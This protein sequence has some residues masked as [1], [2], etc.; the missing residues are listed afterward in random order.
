MTLIYEKNLEVKKKLNIV[1]LLTDFGL[2]NSYVAQ[3][4]GVIYSIAPQ[5]KCVNITNCV[6][7]QKV[8]VG[9]F[10]LESSVDFF[11]KGTIHLGVVDPGVGTSNLISA[12][13]QD[14]FIQKMD[15]SGNFIWAKS[16]GGTGT[17]SGYGRAIAVDGSGNIYTTGSFR[18]VVD[19]DPGTGTSNLTSAGSN[20][21]FVHKMDSS[22]SFIWA[23]TMG[24]TNS[25]IGKSIAT[26]ASGNI[27]TTGWF[28]GTVDFDP[29]AGTSNHTSAGSNEVFIQK[30]DPLGN[31]IW[32]KSIGGIDYAIANSI[33]LDGSGNI[34][35]T[36]YFGGTVDFDP[37]SGINNLSS[38]GN[39]D[40]FVHKMSQSTVGVSDNSIDNQVS[41]YPNPS[42]GI[43]NFTKTKNIASVHFIDIMGKTVYSTTST[44]FIDITHLNSGLYFVKTISKNNNVTVHKLYLQ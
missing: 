9:S 37:G 26:D 10:I 27:Y 44:T 28:V 38:V 43:V 34:Y 1:T 30:L 20:D 22:G 17:S 35:T 39:D 32:V 7:H 6:P 15:S 31:F 41:I 14:V 18:G 25:E 2:K 11:P 23:K 24:G 33:T 36:G 3:M 42:N 19:F 13:D 21:I 16:M 8:R 40:V 29:G 12:G 4:K 5:A